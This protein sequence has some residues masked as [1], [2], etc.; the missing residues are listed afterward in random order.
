V[1]KVTGRGLM[2]EDCGEEE[3]HGQH[4][5]L[6]KD[7]SC[8]SGSIPPGFPAGADFPIPHSQK[9]QYSYTWETVRRPDDDP[10]TGIQILS[11]KRRWLENATLSVGAQK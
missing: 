6:A 3:C 10:R 1:G 4:R 8:A 5:V 11:I 2:L 7:G 9:G